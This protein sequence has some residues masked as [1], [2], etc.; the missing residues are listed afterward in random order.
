MKVS[1]I[2]IFILM[3]V[4]GM[5]CPGYSQQENVW[6][7]GHNAGIDFNGNVPTAIK[8]ALF[9]REGTASVCDENG[10][11]LFYT[12]GSICWDRNHNVM[13][14]GS[15]LT[16][17]PN[18]TG[19]YPTPTGSSCQ[20][21]VIVPMPDNPNKYYVFSLSSIEN[22]NNAG[23]LYY[24]IVNMQLN[25]G[26][27]DMEPGYKGVL[28]D[29]LL[30]EMLSAVTGGRCNIWVLTIA[31]NRPVLK[32]YSID[33]AGINPIP[34]V[35]DL[36]PA[37]THGEHAMIGK[38]ELSPDRKLLA[39]NRGGLGLYSFDGFS[40]VATG[41]ITL[42]EG[43]AQH[44][45]GLC[46]SPDNSKLYTNQF[47]DI[48]QYDFSSNDSLLSINSKT[49]IGRRTWVDIKR[50]PDNKIYVLN[51]PSVDSFLSVIHFPNLAGTACQF[52]PDAFPLWPGTIGTLGFPNNVPVFKRD[53]LTSLQA[54]TAPPFSA[55]Y[56]LQATDTTGNGYSWDNGASG[57]GRMV[58]ES[59]VYWVKYYTE[60]CRFRVDT[61]IV[62]FLCKLPQL[63]TNPSC[64]EDRNGSAWMTSMDDR[65]NY[66]FIWRNSTGD[67]LS[68]TDSLADVPSGYYTVQITTLSG[69]DTII[70]FP[71]REEDHKIS[72]EMD[73]LVCEGDIVNLINTSDNHF[74]EYYWDFGDN[75]S[76]TLQQAQ[77]I[78]N[79]SGSYNVLLAGY[80]KVCSDTFYKTITVD[81]AVKNFSFTTDRKEICV[82]E[83]IHFYAYKD[84][85]TTALY[86][87]L[88]MNHSL[89][90]L[91]GHIQHAYAITGVIPVTL[92]AKFRVC[93][94][95]SFTDTII[96]HA[97]PFVDLGPDSVICLHGAPVILF[98]HQPHYDDYTYL[99]STGDTTANINVIHHGNYN[100][101]VANE[102]GCTTTENISVAKDCYVD[103][104]NVFT[105]NGDGINDYFFPRQLLSGSV[106]RFRM[107][108]FNRW[109]QM[110]FDTIHPEGRGWDGKFNGKEQPFGTY[111]YRI[112]AEYANGRNEKYEGNV[113]LIR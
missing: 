36:L 100:L 23:R 75:H 50:G 88:G 67:T 52:E 3:A 58:Y 14:N 85:T 109:G 72:F 105:P 37:N 20:S 19:M 79:Q 21:S 93:P 40:G 55:E 43:G 53:T 9:A 107:Q 29:S 89:L 62:D 78:Y 66:S 12:E 77:H 41:K 69:C 64:R 99:W 83:E 49:L 90:T 92:T 18:I 2:I 96:V 63:F 104:P 38:I 27:G 10:Q 16:G 108:V 112:E 82:G 101:T 70:S 91:N 11:L 34:V 22:G 1:Y 5:F 25:N 113:T 76:S 48:Y 33:A 103:I 111:V 7:F 86:W 15:A 74:T 68:V 31:V 110:I 8:T 6:A 95:I 44:F 46:F 60:P 39:I 73:T 17:L 35:S 102:H 47:H 57:I 56:Y 51:Y 30:T 84:Y 71:I 26:L 54:Y 98:N 81:A 94:D 32:V 87:N 42:G 59:G 45:F 80:G 65:V 4:A 97:F 106:N 28:L 13:P 61:F 24:S